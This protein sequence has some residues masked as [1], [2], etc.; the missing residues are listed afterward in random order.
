MRKIYIYSTVVEIDENI[1]KEEMIEGNLVDLLNKEHEISI[2]KRNKIIKVFEKN[3]IA[4]H[5]IVCPD[6]FYDTKNQRNRKQLYEEL[7]IKV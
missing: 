1:T 4:I 6:G 3:N 2:E 7:R 5:E